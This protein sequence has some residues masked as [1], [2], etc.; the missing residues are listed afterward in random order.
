MLLNLFNHIFTHLFE[1]VKPMAKHKHIPIKRFDLGTFKRLT[2]QLPLA[3]AVRQSRA[4]V[5][6]CN[7]ELHFDPAESTLFI[8]P[9][10]ITPLSDAG[11]VNLLVSLPLS[12]RIC[13][14]D[15]T[16]LNEALELYLAS[17]NSVF[18]ATTELFDSSS[19]PVSVRMLNTSVKSWKFESEEYLKRNRRGALNAVYFTNEGQ[20][21]TL[22]PSVTIQ[23]LFSALNIYASM[24]VLFTLKT[25]LSQS[26]LQ[27]LKELFE[28]MTAVRAVAQN[29]YSI[30]DEPSSGSLP[31]FSSWGPKPPEPSATKCS[32]TLPAKQAAP[33]HV[34]EAE[35]PHQ[36]QIPRPPDIAEIVRSL[37]EDY[38]LS[39]SE[40]GPLVRDCVKRGITT[41]EGMVE[42]YTNPE[43]PEMTGAPRS[44]CKR[45]KSGEPASS[46][47]AQT[48]LTMEDSIRRIRFSNLI[49]DYLRSK[50]WEGWQV[51]WVFCKCFDFGKQTCAIGAKHIK[52]VYIERN[53]RRHY[54]NIL[55]TPN[56]T[57]ALMK[58]LDLIVDHSSSSVS[59]KAGAM[60]L[61]PRPNNEFG[62][63][64]M[65][66][67]LQWIRTFQNG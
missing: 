39:Y 20:V 47:E 43:L 11:F 24:G 19:L 31:W 18:R 41:L 36:K 53:L 12:P 16:D 38:S 35:Q 22:G 65:T 33:T 21:I 55:H 9:R 15:R 44:S 37:A 40:I 30:V 14:P 28:N 48:A 3:E 2:I 63:S 54:S 34:H 5:T 60:A 52:G 7:V 32:A 17:Y 23:S 29:R 49:E 61:D 27:Q 10:N 25:N 26:V 8:S 1:A 62:R 46:A 13:A 50:G 56:Q 4:I 57:L 51:A 67:M 42:E 64:I 45:K 59:S 6:S 58:S 66:F